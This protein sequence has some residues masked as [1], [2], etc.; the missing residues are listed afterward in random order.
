MESFDLN[1][2]HYEKKDRSI[3]GGCPVCTL[4]I[5]L[6]QSMTCSNCKVETG[7]TN[8]SSSLEA[9]IVKYRQ[10]NRFKFD[11]LVFNIHFCWTVM[12]LGACLLPIPGFIS[13]FGNC[14]QLL[15]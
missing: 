4:V 12:R 11:Y 15:V 14:S 2:E 8:E 3:Y 1:I 7:G 6:V 9:D 13:P 10:E 5:E